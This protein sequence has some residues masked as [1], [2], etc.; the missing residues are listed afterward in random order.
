MTTIQNHVE[1]AESGDPT[2]DPRAFRR[3][4]AQ[5]PTGVT[6]ITA[7]SGD[8][9]VGVTA[10]SF[11]S[12]SLDPP[13]VLWSIDR[14]STSFDTFLEATH[15]AVNV[16]SEDQTDLS[17]RF[18]RT[19]ETKFDGVDWLAGTGG[20]P[21]LNGVAAQLVCKREIE[22]D[23]GDHIILIGRVEQY[24]RFEQEPLVFAKGRYALA[25]DRPESGPPT[26]SDSGDPESTLLQYLLRA[27][28]GISEEFQFYRQ[29]EGL[30]VNQSRVLALLTRQPAET[31]TDIMR[32]ALV[33]QRAAE[34]SIASLL[35]RG[36]ARTVA[37]G[38]YE[39]TD[40]GRDVSARVRSKLLEVETDV[41]SRVPGLDLAATR[42]WLTAL[43][44][45]AQQSK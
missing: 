10:N 13:L 16:L 34:D 40:A 33:G 7:S 25:V 32:G 29:Q 30:T 22:H 17:T 37:R 42:R 26:S 35:D 15:F 24:N 9:Q 14:K 5:Y 4:L 21:L 27:Y 12:V 41:A 31:L 38:G 6:I 28:E 36:L 39:I 3:A 44:Q 20:A 2:Q 8:R 45:A 18:S 23:G 19:S 11:S 43:A 1:L